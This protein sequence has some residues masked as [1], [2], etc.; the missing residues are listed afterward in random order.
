MQV[1]T[2]R[3]HFFTLIQL[4]CLAVLWAVKISPFSLALPFVL[5]LTIPLRMFLTG[6]VFSVTEMKCVRT[7]P[8][9]LQSP[10]G[11]LGYWCGDFSVVTGGVCFAAG[12][13]WCQS[14]VWGGTRRGCVRRVPAA[15]NSIVSFMFHSQ[16]LKWT[17]TLTANNQVALKYAFVNI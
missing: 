6:R 17:Q 9:L 4:V 7:A 8:Y 2:M 3:M 12:C 14:D 1:K 10:R 16:T 15:L 11:A 13:G 5:I